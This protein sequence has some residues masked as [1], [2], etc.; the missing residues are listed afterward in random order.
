VRFTSSWD[1][2]I[3]TVRH[4]YA[5]SFTHV[6]TRAESTPDLL[7]QGPAFVLYVLMD[8]IVDQYFPIV[9]ALTEELE[10]LEERVLSEAFNRETM[11]HIYKLKRDLISVKHVVAPLIEMS[12]RLQRF[13]DEDLIPVQTRPYFRDVYDHTLR[14]NEAIDSLRD[15]LGTVL[16][17][18]LSLMSVSQNADMR[19]LAA[20]AAI[21][22]VATAI[23][24]IYGMNFDYM[25]ELRWRLG[26][27]FAVGL[28]VLACLWVYMQFKKAKWL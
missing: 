10:M 9:H 3:L 19:R 16:E 7:K 4:A 24:G 12:G 20:W 15:F 28:I 2:F 21:F 23:A 6:R 13:E 27:P 8:F 11:A 1:K 22:A 17:A 14:I 5:T 26:Y 25:P 18:H